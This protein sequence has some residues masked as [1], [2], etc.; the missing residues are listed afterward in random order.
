[1]IK[2][3]FHF[4]FTIER[5]LNSWIYCYGLDIVIPF[6]IPTGSQ[7]IRGIDKDL[8]VCNQIMRL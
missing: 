6:L 8:G 1:M 5:A 3:G 7:I 4:Y 2:T